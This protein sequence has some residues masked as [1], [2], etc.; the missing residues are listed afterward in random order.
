MRDVC[1]IRAYANTILPVY[2]GVVLNSFLALAADSSDRTIFQLQ[3]SAW[4][5]HEGAP[6]AMNAIAQTTDGFL[7]LGTKT[8]LY[9]FDGA[10]FERYKPQTGKDRAG[11]DVSTLKATPN[12]GLWIGYSFGGADFL[13]DGR[14]DSYPVGPASSTGSEGFPGGTVRRFALDDKGVV[15]AGTTTGI[16][17]FEGSQW[18]RL[19]SEWG[20]HWSF[21]RDLLVDRAGTLWIATAEAVVF[22]PRGEKAFR[23]LDSPIDDATGLAQAPDGAIWVAE[24]QVVRPIAMTP[25]GSGRALPGIQAQYAFEFIFDR[26][27]TLWIASTDG[28]IRVRH[29]ELPGA[30][31]AS[32]FSPEIERFSKND[33]ATAVTQ[34][35]VLQDRE[36]NIWVGTLSGLDRFRE[37]SVVPAAPQF[38]TGSAL[39]VAGSKEDVWAWVWSTRPP[40]GVDLLHIGNASIEVQRVQ[41][42]IECVQRD[43]EGVIWTAGPNGVRR[44]AKGRF[45][46]VPMPE[47]IAKKRGFDGIVHDRNGNLWVAYLGAGVYLRQNGTWTHGGKL[48]NLLRPTPWS[49]TEDSLGRIWFGYTR[50]A[51]ALYDGN[52]YRTFTST[53]GLHIIN[54]QTIYGHGRH[55][56]AG[57]IQGL[58]LYKENEHRFQAIVAEGDMEL[59]GV[60]GIAERANGDLWLSTILESSASPQR[61]S[62]GQLRIRHIAYAMTCSMRRTAFSESLY[63]LVN[64]G[65]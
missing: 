1:K 4:A 63:S 31:D 14:I 28:L 55:V 21:P 42:A 5:A 24:S 26:A 13:K 43:E 34:T 37:T 56:W 23:K 12:G 44:F 8:G 60:S 52:A 35:S 50:N 59:R 30:S 53:D 51:V 2:L 16:A 15:W 46:P 10:R 9:R 48:A 61:R 6:G 7:W 19:G 58:A 64:S 25:M 32:A 27:G 54:V 47:E 40:P 20:Y 39:I 38:N 22:V 33:G 36:G 62:D 65:S 17:R 41:N 45:E 18:R 11:D 57:G 3:H 29:K 49:L